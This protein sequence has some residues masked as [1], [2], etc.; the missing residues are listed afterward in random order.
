MEL[1]G[2]IVRYDRVTRSASATEKKTV[3]MIKTKYQ[4]NSIFRYKDRAF[5]KE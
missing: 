5:K 4:H 3:L 1:F 2:T